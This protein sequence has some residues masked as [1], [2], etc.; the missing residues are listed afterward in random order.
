LSH[1]L[2]RDQ[3][4]ERGVHS[5]QNGY[6]PPEIFHYLENILFDNIPARFEEINIETIWAWHLTIL[7]FFENPTYFLFG[8]KPIKVDIILS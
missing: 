7:H 4:Y 8:H 5:F 6:V 1:L 2:F 3:G